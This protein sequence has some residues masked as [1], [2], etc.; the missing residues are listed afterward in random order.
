MSIEDVQTNLRIPSNIKEFLQAS[1]DAAGRSLSAEAAYRLAQAFDLEK[2]EREMAANIRAAREDVERARHEVIHLRAKSTADE[3]TI[4]AL[5]ERINL[6]AEARTSDIEGA[7][8]NLEQRIDFLVE[9]VGFAQRETESAREA[10]RALAKLNKV[11]GNYL[12]IVAGMVGQTTP[13]GARLMQLI[14]DIGQALHEDNFT[15][16][17]EAAADIVQMGKVEKVV[18]L[19]G[20]RTVEI[21][22]QPVGPPQRRIRTPSRKK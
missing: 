17:V 8:K 22:P 13:E 7:T 15:A 18:E 5:E 14:K 21:V 3:R 19:G 10:Q 1:A 20:E 9:K 16:A 4:A 6:I 12:A 11:V 2:V